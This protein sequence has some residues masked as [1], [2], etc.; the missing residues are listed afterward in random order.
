MS[1]CVSDGIIELKLTDSSTV[2]RFISLLDT[3]YKINADIKECCR[4]CYKAT[5]ISFKSNSL[6]EFLELCDNKDNYDRLFSFLKCKN[7][8]TVF[9][10]AVFCSCGTVS[11]PKKSYTLEFRMPNR[12]RAE[13]ISSVISKY[14]LV[15]PCITDRKGAVGA[16][17]RNESSIE[18][19]LTACGASKALFTFFDVAVEKNLRNTENR[20]TNCVAKNISKSVMAAAVQVSAIESL[21]ATG[22]F[23]E[24]PDDLKKTARLRI[25]Y[26][27]VSLTEL[28]ELH[29]PSISK[30]G[31]NHRLSRLIE[32]AKKNDLI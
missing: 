31:L 18:D 3:V 26:P 14:G 27:D 9:L 13:L 7:C 11:D 1:A 17:Y 20:A 25:E 21:I 15:A 6:S 19:V 28:V 29:K 4:G 8:E 16:F 22:I 30:S 10:R 24:L 32:E 2:E 5:Q 12:Q 23:D